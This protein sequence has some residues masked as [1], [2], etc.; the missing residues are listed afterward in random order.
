MLVLAIIAVVVIV[1]IIM[2]VVITVIII[3][4]IVIIAVVVIIQGK[5][6]VCPRRNPDTLAGPIILLSN[7]ASNFGISGLLFCLGISKTLAGP[8]DL[9]FFKVLD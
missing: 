1:I 3:V 2:I 7:R 8:M 5:R 9:Q 4:V 6:E